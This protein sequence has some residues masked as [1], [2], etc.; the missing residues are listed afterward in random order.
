MQEHKRRDSCKTNDDET[1]IRSRRRDE[2][3]TAG[4]A[5]T[6]RALFCRET[7]LQEHQL[8]PRSTKASKA[9]GEEVVADKGELSCSALRDAPAVKARDLG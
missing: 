8:D 5:S 3:E 2:R 9:T 4:G 1:R 7:E 6:A